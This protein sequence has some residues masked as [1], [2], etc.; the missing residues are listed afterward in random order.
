MEFQHQGLYGFGLRNYELK[1]LGLKAQG[2]EIK[3]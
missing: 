3:I 2:F 1:V